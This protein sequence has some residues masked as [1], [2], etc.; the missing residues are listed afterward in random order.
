M[1]PSQLSS[2][3]AREKEVGEIVDL[4]PR[5]IS[6]EI[7]IFID[8]AVRNGNSWFMSREV[9][10]PEV[11]S[12]TSWL[13]AFQNE[14]PASVDEKVFDNLGLDQPLLGPFDDT[15]FSHKH[16]EEAF[17]VIDSSVFLPSVE[18]LSM[19]DLCSNKTQ[20]G[21]IADQFNHWSQPSDYMV[22]AGLCPL[23]SVAFDARR[24]SRDSASFT[25]PNGVDF[26]PPMEPALMAPLAG[27]LEVDQFLDYVGYKDLQE[28][29]N[30]GFSA[31]HQIV[32]EAN[33]VAQESPRG[34]PQDLT[35]RPNIE[36]EKDEPG[37]VD[38]NSWTRGLGSLRRRLSYS[39]SQMSDIITLFR[40]FSVSTRG[41]RQSSSTVSTSDNL[42]GGVQSEP[43]EVTL[44]TMYKSQNLLSPGPGVLDYGVGKLIVARKCSQCEVFCL[45]SFCTTCETDATADLDVK[46][47][48]GFRNS[49]S[50]Q[51]DHFN[52][53]AL[54]VIAAL[55]A[56]HGNFID[57]IRSWHHDLNDTNIAGQTFLH[58]MNPDNWLNWEWYLPDLLSELLSLGFKFGRVDQHGVSACQV[59]LQHKLH[60]NTLK[61]IFRMMTNSSSENRIS[62]ICRDNLG[63]TCLS[64]L[65]FLEEEAKERDSERF[66][67]LRALRKKL[68][69]EFR[70]DSGTLRQFLA[71]DTI[72]QPSSMQDYDGVENK[73]NLSLTEPFSEDRY[74]RNG[75]H[76]LA[77]AR[78]TQSVTL[79]ENKTW[80][81]HELREL[82]LTRLLREGS[83]DVNAYDKA[84]DTPLMTFICSPQVLAEEKSHPGKAKSYLTR[85][86][87]AGALIDMRN[88]SGE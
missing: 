34:M 2:K 66:A 50:P 21:N 26:H 58:V 88:R 10:P 72:P 35:V 57:F 48:L 36:P 84:G 83:V 78:L 69:E 70:L 3:V 5:D 62:M 60:H 13:T 85:L 65:Y 19:T 79:F 6:S 46:N 55:G 41:S 73:F 7:D 43:R 80:A 82:H 22:D 28:N 45:N 77:V 56:D 86:V 87:E 61:N 29:T 15:A 17:P 40:G 32:P 59:L 27:N 11:S 4:A 38:R 68:F 14:G 47:Y 75:L 20:D 12:D 44:E 71:F 18:P 63:R 64:Q 37:I 8:Q 39:S 81:R 30:N 23:E 67:A 53:T 9:P 54:H 1:S 25:T 33:P 42:G 52:N 24:I 51:S 74:G 16:A 31:G 49:G 76:C